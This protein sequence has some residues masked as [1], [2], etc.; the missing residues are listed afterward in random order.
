MKKATKIVALLLAIAMT[1]FALASCG[2]S[3]NTGDAATLKIGCSGPLTGGAAQY[4]N[5]VKNGVELAVKE[6]N[7]AGG[8]NGIKLEVLFEDDEHDAQ[9]AKNAYNV[10]KDKGAKVFLGTVTSIPCAAVCAETKKDNMFQITPSGSSVD[11]IDAPNAFRVCFSDPNQGTA[12]AQYLADNKLATKVAVI[13]NSGDPYSSGIFNT[14]KAE[15]AK[16]NLPIV[17]EQ[18]FTDA[19]NTDFSTQLQ[20]IKESGADLVFLPIYYE[21][22]AMILQQASKASLNVKYFGCDGLDGVINQLGGDAKLADGVML[23]T[24]FAADAKDE[25]TQKFT[26]S[27]KAAYND[28]IPDQFAADGYDAVYVIKAA[29]EKAGVKDASISV[30]DLCEA[31]KGAMTQI[32]VDGVTGSMTWTAEGEPSKTPKA[33]VIQNG[34]YKAM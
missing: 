28:A 1:T 12:S 7:E 9:K 19:N 15:A 3:N 22:A 26:A 34:G 2:E 20:K 24:P 17:S 29:M 31:I 30:S 23:L 18:T 16:K 10:V 21:Q 6:I 13:Y 33:M 32:T 5:S 25:K 8:V 14:F 4:G 27:Y 11:C